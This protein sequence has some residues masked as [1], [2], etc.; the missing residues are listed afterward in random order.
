MDMRR[1]CN[2]IQPIAVLL[3]VPLLFTPQLGKGNSP[4]GN[5]NIEAN[6]PFAG[7]YQLTL[8]RWWPLPFGKDDAGFV[9]P[10]KRIRLFSERGT[11][12]FE[13]DGFLV[14]RIP[15][16]NG[17]VHGRGGPAYWQMKSARQIEIVWTDGFTGVTL[18]LE[19]YG[20]ELRGWA[21][22]H[23]D[24]PRLVPRIAHVTARPIACG[25]EIPSE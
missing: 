18:N 13:K 2:F 5:Q 17:K 23:F 1:R 21:H 20:N 22:P 19:K 16:A 15:E 6:A 25:P 12:G 10:S 8:G 7:C 11:K 9:T 3:M 14:R 4:V 24:S